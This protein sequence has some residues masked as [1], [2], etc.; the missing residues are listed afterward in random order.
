MHKSERGSIQALLLTVVALLAA[1]YAVVF[2]VF[3]TVVP[4][5]YIGI[6]QNYFSFGFGE[7]G[8]Q[9][10]GL[11]PGLHLKIPF[12]TTIHLIPRDFQFVHF[13]T[14]ELDKQ[15][16]EKRRALSSD[17]IPEWLWQEIK[18]EDPLDI[19]TADG[20][21]VRTDVT[22]ILRYFPAVGGQ[23]RK[24]DKATPTIKTET[25]EEIPLPHFIEEAHGGPGDLVNTY[26]I[27][28]EQQLSR[29]A[30]LAE[31]EIKKSL[32]FLS[33]LNYYDPVSREGRVLSAQDRISDAVNPAGVEIWGTLIRRYLYQDQAID[34]QIYE[35]NLQEQQEALNKTLRDLA[36]QK[37]LTDKVLAEWEAKISVLT[38]Q[39]QTEAK[40]IRSQGD[41]QQGQKMAEG[42]LKVAEA[43]A[44]VDSERAHVLSAVSGADVYVAREMLPFLSSLSGG[45]VSGFDPFDISKW[46]NRLVGGQAE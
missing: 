16:Q 28:R 32:S 21:K 39:G 44:R 42:D 36:E 24:E 18:V 1:L 20:S 33:T 38:V 12:I 19:P 43:K 23:Q 14:D 27:D 6:R 30:Q 37:A 7:K 5:N 41:L 31:N 10:K 29:I 22:L 4:P 46:L 13:L 9:D 35:K 2:F 34:D 3:G 25:T 11:A 40:V 8:F 15:P 17:F 26:T 45:V